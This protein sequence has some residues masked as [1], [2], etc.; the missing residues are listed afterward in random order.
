MASHKALKGV[1]RSVA[2]SFTSLMN[3]AANDYV[4]GHLL[5]AARMTG[6]MR[7]E[8]D[9]LSGVASPAGLLVRPVADS[10]GIYCRDFSSLVGRSG[11]DIAFVR[12]AQLSVEF[13][14]SISRPYSRAPRLSE[15]PYS[16][17]VNIQDD[18][19]KIYESKLD[20][21]WYPET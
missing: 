2:D 15:S 5:K 21:W 19:G 20:G 7:L 8:V 13:D 1:S 16:C 9:L 11:S 4:M 18:R 17:V 3:Y 12:S 10:V 14:I 6:L